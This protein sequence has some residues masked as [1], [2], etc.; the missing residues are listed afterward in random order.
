MSHLADY[1]EQKNSWARIFGGQV[2]NV[3][4]LDRLAAQQ[5]ADNLC[6]DLSP[7]NLTCDGELD[8][9]T[10]QRRSQQYRG[11]LKELQARFD[12]QVEEY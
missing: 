11:A 4:N 7:E 2:Y 10:V 12:L 5:L 9:Y 8:R 3:K 1:I 6:C